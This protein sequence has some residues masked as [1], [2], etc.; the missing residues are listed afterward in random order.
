[1]RHFVGYCSMEKRR[2]QK[3]KSSEGEW[4][5]GTNSLVLALNFDFVS[6]TCALHFPLSFSFSPFFTLFFSFLSLLH[7]LTH[8]TP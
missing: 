3:I 5:R 7:I 8:L 4:P 2:Y 6:P 1:M